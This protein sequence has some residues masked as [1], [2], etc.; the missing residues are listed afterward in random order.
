M[1]YLIYL[2]TT[3]FILLST[4]SALCG[5]VI[6]NYYVSPVGCAGGCSDIIAY[7]NCDALGDLTKYT[8]SATVG[9][10]ASFA[11]DTSTQAVGTGSWQGNGTT[12]DVITIP[13]ASNVDL[14]NGRIGFYLRI[15][16]TSTTGHVLTA[17]TTTDVRMTYYNS[18]SFRVYYMG[19]D[20]YLNYGTLTQGV[21]YFMEMA[22]DSGTDTVT[23][24]KDG[25]SIGTVTG[26]TAI[27]S[28]NLYFGDAIGNAT[29]MAIDQFISSSDNA[30]DIY[31]VRATTN[32]N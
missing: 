15:D 7:H 18:G 28:T 21:W 29:P 5:I 9:Y 26:S 24:Y 14:T 12:Y 16:N 17:T 13:I 4:S 10:D 31:A 3:C 8:G 6:G 27:T 2:T 22:F 19:T 32:F 30:R 20:D 25:V 23:V 11:L 1:K